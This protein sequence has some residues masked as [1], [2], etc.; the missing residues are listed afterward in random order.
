MIAQRYIRDLG[1]GSNPRLYLGYGTEDFFATAQGLL[2]DLLPHDHVFTTPGG[3]TPKTMKK[4]WRI[5]LEKDVL[6]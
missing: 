3:H 6:K 2:G 4:V 1:N 5:F